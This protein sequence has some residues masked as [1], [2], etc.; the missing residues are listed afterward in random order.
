MPL[1]VIGVREAARELRV[2][3]SRVRELLAQGALPGEKLDGRWVMRRED[4]LARRREPPPP[5]RP[6]SATNAWL[7]LLEASQEPLPAAADAMAQWR[8]RRA[9]RHPGLT[10]MRPRLERRAQAH[11]LWALPAELPALRDTEGVVLSGSNAAGALGL[12][13]VAPDAI[14]GYVPAERLRTLIAE[15]ALQDAERARANVTL[16]AVPEGAWMLDGRELAPAAAVALDLASYPDPRSERAGRRL[17]DEL[18]YRHRE[19]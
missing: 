2:V 3:P 18:D 17:L 16:R 6:L 8:V 4:V 9:L 12:E 5:G 14:D 7:L 1:D 10:A 13:L 11:C 15:H 19:R